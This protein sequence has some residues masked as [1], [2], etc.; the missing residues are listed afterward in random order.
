MWHLSCLPFYA[1]SSWYQYILTWDEQNTLNDVIVFD[2]CIVA[3]PSHV[4]PVFCYPDLPLCVHN[5]WVSVLCCLSQTVC[6]TPGWFCEVS[7]CLLLIPVF[8]F[9]IFF[10]CVCCL[11]SLL[12]SPQCFH[13]W[14]LLPFWIGTLQVSLFLLLNNCLQQIHLVVCI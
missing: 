6:W 13:S 12:V 2:I 10:A 3:P 11:F 14:D 7:V 5:Y 8:G 4:L 9:S 1:I